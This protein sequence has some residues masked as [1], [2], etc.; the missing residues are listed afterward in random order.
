MQRRTSLAA[1]L[2]VST[3]WALAAC[4]IPSGKA[5]EIVGDAPSDFDQSTGTE[6]EPFAPTT[7]PDSTVQ[8]YLK[9]AAGDPDGLPDRLYAF[10]TDDRVFSDAASGIDLLSRVEVTTVTNTVE[11]ATVRVTGSVIGRYLPDGSV[12]M[13]AAPRQYEEEFALDREGFQD[14]WSITSLPTQ[15]ILD[16]GHF[17]ATYDPAPLYFQATQEELL[18][19]DLRWAY[20]DLSA[21]AD[22]RLR[23]GWLLQGPSDFARFSARNAIP[24]GTI[25]KP[26]TGEGGEVH[27]ELSPGETVEPDTVDAIAAQ[28]AWS[29]GLESDFV[30]TVDGQDVFEGS[31]SDWRTWNAIPDDV[32]E[33]GYFIAEETVWEYTSSRPVTTVSAEHPWVGFH[34][35]GLRQV[36]V[37]PGSQIAAIVQGPDG[38]VLQVG[39]DE[40]SMRTIDGLSADLAS[41]QW[42][43]DGTVLVIDAGVPTAVDPISRSKQVLQVGEGVTS[44]AI[45]ADGLRLAFVADGSAWVA[46][47]S[48]DLDG[49]IQAGEP[50]L[51]GPQITA[52]TAVAW[53]S[54]NYL[55][56]AGVSG[57]DRLFRVAL[58]NSHIEPQTG[59]AGL[60]F[61][62]IAASPAD[63]ESPTNN[64]GEPVLVVAN[65]SLYRVH[66]TLQVV[67]NDSQAVAAT[68]PFTVLNS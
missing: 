31:L 21:D 39:T 6:V 43:A 13:S 51:I 5:P 22:R 44:M 28:I 36:A 16:Y 8:N 41:P 40:E 62:Q 11:A 56:V 26:S 47:L 14:V 55:W 46:P 30:L 48:V 42:L 1:A 45:S 67:E 7:E 20:N 60:V 34:V 53:S 66:T 65:S 58:D 12:R 52:V 59:T 68:A 17:D 54:E 63:P 15:V 25:G 18:V 29:L 27:I 61:A 35:D 64:R 3:A 24:E 33:T 2:A 49:N 37:G 38:F 9:S 57:D 32:P 19:P 50:R 10:T 4:G 23:L